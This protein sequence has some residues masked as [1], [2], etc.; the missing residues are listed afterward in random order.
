M[1]NAKANFLLSF[2]ICPQLY[3]LQTSLLS[4]HTNPMML[5]RGKTKRRWRLVKKPRRTRPRKRRPRKQSPGEQPRCGSSLCRK[6]ISICVK[7]DVSETVKGAL[8]RTGGNGVFRDIISFAFASHQAA[9]GA[10]RVDHV[11][12]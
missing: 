1:C 10:C 6:C 12:L 7:Y 2:H 3:T 9:R 8:C 11:R 4:A 5:F